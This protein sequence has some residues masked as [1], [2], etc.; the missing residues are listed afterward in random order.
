MLHDALQHPEFQ[1]VDS[2]LPLLLGTIPTVPARNAVSEVFSQY[3]GQGPNALFD[4][5]MFSTT[6][7]DP[8]AVVLGKRVYHRQGRETGNA[9]GKGPADDWSIRME[10][11]VADL[12]QR[13]ELAARKAPSDEGKA[14][15]GKRFPVRL[16]DRGKTVARY[17]LFWPEDV[18]KSWKRYDI[19]PLEI[20]FIRLEEEGIANQMVYHYRHHN[21]DAR[22]TKINGGVWFDSFDSKSQM[23]VDVRVT[24]PDGGL[25]VPVGKENKNSGQRTTTQRGGRRSTQ[26]GTRKKLVVEILT[27]AI[28]QEREAS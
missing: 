25:G 5:G 22:E 13:F 9:G 26:R 6:T 8:V 17:D 15:S 23:S 1:G 14:A 28:P 12:C 3:E 27:V 2:R 7:L 4:M 11:Y 24:T 19:A 16:H 10:P 18:E 21:R 20:H